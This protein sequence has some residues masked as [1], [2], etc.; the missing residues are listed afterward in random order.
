M[1]KPVLKELVVY[2]KEILLKSSVDDHLEEI[3]YVFQRT[4]FNSQGKV[5]SEI[6][7]DAEG[8][9]V[10][11]YEFRYN[12]QGFLAEETM[13]EDD[14]FVAEHKTFEYDEKGN[15]ARELRHYTD[16]SFDTIQYQY[17]D[18]GLLKFKEIIDPDGDRES[19]EAY[20]YENGLVSHYVMHDADGDITTEKHWAFDEKGNTIEYT[21]FDGFEGVSIRKT[22]EYYPSGSKKEILTYNDD[23]KL[24]E[25]VLMKENEEGQLIEVL[26]ES[27]TRKNTTHFSYDN[28]G[29]IIAQEEFDRNGNLISRVQRTYDEQKQ[30]QT[31]DV[32][33]DGSG[34]G[35]SRNYTLRHDYVYF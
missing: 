18:Q 8:K 27:V 22:T 33:I 10:Q 35:L 5:V 7:Y 32:F 28:A 3:E 26:E 20:G 30:L 17:N 4:L 25:K 34:R 9:I 19:T 12:N 13:K 31:S 29:N 24:V 15:I 21:E 23:G 16:G 1:S 2:K 11:E 14:G 6:H